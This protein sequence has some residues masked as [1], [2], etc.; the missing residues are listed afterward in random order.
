LKDVNPLSI[1][2][3]TKGK[4]LVVTFEAD[5][6]NKI[7]NYY[8]DGKIQP[9]ASKIEFSVNDVERARNAVGAL[10]KSVTLLKG[11]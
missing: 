4:W 8:K 10:K 5:F 3:E 11:K 6:K 7:F 2:V 1:Q 9:Y